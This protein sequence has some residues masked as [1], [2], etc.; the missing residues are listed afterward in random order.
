[1]FARKVAARLKPNSLTE[2]KKLMEREILPW[3]RMQEGFLDL[4]TLAVPDSREVATITFWNH[5]G[6]AQACNSGGCPEALRILGELLD[7]PPHVKTFE[8]VSSTFRSF[9]GPCEA[10]TVRER[11]GISHASAQPNDSI[12]VGD[13]SLSA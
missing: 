13:P 8:V 5:K 1:V 7:G 4:L 2:F 11:E 12:P 3:L 6:K 9:A 10:G